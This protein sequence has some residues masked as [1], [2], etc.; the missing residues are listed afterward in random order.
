[1]RLFTARVPEGW[2]VRAVPLTRRTA[3]VIVIDY[4]MG[5][6]RSIV[7][8][9][10][11]VGVAVSASSSAADLENASKII[12]PGVGAFA[13]GMQHLRELDLIPTLDRC[14]HE[15]GIPVLGIC[16]GMHLFAKASDEG[17]ARGLGWI[18]SHVRR[19]DFSDIDG[20]RRVPNFGWNT[21][22]VKRDTRLLGGVDPDQRFYFAHSYHL[23]CADPQD[24]VAT[25]HYGYEYPAVVQCG[26]VC[27]IQF[28]PEKSHRRGFE[29]VRRFAT[30][31]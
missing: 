16:L 24:I 19:F 2:R 28:H 11:K 5:N 23:D 31:L 12:I 1:M 30:S 13:A 18:D 10:G 17:G 14:V 9:L 8:K 26:S 15:A 27:G 29:I 6:V 20:S 25:T 3:I 7:H 22:E 21:I 4:G